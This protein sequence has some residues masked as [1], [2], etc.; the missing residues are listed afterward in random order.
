MAEISIWSAAIIV[1][2][3]MFAASIGFV[4]AGILAG[5]RSVKY[6]TNRE[7]AAQSLSAKSNNRLRK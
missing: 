7:T 6:Q 5:A 1:M 2:L 3:M 4:T